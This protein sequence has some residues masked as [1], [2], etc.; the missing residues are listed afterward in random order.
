MCYTPT[1]PDSKLDFACYVPGSYSIGDNSTAQ[2]ASDE[3]KPNGILIQGMSTDGSSLVGWKP[4][5]CPIETK[6][7][8]LVWT[9]PTENEDCTP[10]L[11]LAGFNIYWDGILLDT[12][13]PDENSYEVTGV[14]GTISV[15]TVKAFDYNGNESKP[16]SPAVILL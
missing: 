8:K 12:I 13:G 16:S 11:D 9:I 14:T 2:V 6:D 4:I 10:L 1:V 15:F 7:L 3:C 5:Q